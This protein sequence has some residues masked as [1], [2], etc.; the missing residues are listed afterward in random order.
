MAV[1]DKAGETTGP[2][3]RREPRAS[4]ER[5]VRVSHAV[6]G[7]MGEIEPHVQSPAEQSSR[8]TRHTHTERSK[9]RRRRLR[10]VLVAGALA[11]VVMPTLL[12][13]DEG[14]PIVFFT[15]ATGVLV[16]KGIST[17]VA[18][19]AVTWR[20]RRHASGLRRVGYFAGV[21]AMCIGLGLVAARAFPLGS[22]ITFDAGVL[23]MFVQFLGDD[24]LRGERAPFAA[25]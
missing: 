22:T 8:R 18:L 24:R 2:D 16:M 12:V 5:E 23:L 10:L 25:A 19:S 9:R 21:W 13:P 3:V 11:F 20:L 17:L 1:R 4:V 15:M 7:P 6:E 14:G